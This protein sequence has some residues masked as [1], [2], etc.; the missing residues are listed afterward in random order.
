T[1]RAAAGSDDA[2]DAAR[3]GDPGYHLI[4]E[5]RP[6]LERA[7]GF[8]PP[9][10]LRISRFNV[11]LG[12]GGYVG[13][14]LLVTTALLLLPLWALPGHGVAAAWFGVF[15]LFGFLPASE[16]ATAL[17]NRAITWSFGAMT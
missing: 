15:A 11:R 3:I 4:A 7:I 16:V 5:G 13:A 1:R 12:I 6:A 8:R 9:A 14:I 17:V 10:R 2:V